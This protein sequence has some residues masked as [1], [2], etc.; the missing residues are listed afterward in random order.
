MGELYIY[1]RVPAARFDGALAAVQALQDALRERYPALRARVL[2]RP[3]AGD[4]AQTWMETYACPPDGVTATFEA[5]LRV[6]VQ[7]RPPWWEGERHVERF[8]VLAGRG[9]HPAGPQR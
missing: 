6:A 8:E 7:G 4:G 5:A 9:A 1:Y 2:R 3:P